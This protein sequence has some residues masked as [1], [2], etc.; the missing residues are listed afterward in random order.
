MSFV[1]DLTGVFCTQEVIVSCHNSFW[2]QGWDINCVGG[3]EEGRGDRGDCVDDWVCFVHE[4]ESA[5]F[6]RE[7]IFLVLLGSIIQTA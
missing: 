6:L 1:H 4:R 2:I 5:S 7:K 3:L